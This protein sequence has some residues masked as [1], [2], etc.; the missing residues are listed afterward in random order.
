MIAIVGFSIQ[1]K[2]LGSG[3][4][5]QTPFFFKPFGSYVLT[6]IGYLPGN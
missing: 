3:V 6:N 2:L 1:E 5:D 4:I